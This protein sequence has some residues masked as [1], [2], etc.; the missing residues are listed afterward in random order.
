ME[1]HYSRNKEDWETPPDLFDF[2]HERYRFTIDAA[3]SKENAKLGRYW[4]KE[5]DALSQDWSGERVFCNPP[6]GA[7]SYAF[8]EKAARMEAD[9]SVLLVPARTDT[10]IWHDYVIGW[11]DIWFVRGR[12]K[13]S[14]ARHNAPFPNAILIYGERPEGY[15]LR[16]MGT[17]YSFNPKLIGLPFPD[18][19]L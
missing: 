3:A 16:D 9:L 7:Q 2:L 19:V 14:N 12:L 5:D 4:T 8:I 17:C 6:Y 15:R 10:R 1:V 13:F 18:E 11:A